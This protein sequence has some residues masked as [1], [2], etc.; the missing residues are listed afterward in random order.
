MPFSLLIPLYLDLKAS[1]LRIQ[2]RDYP[3]PAF[4]FPELHPSQLRTTTSVSI[5]GN[6]IVAEAYSPSETNIRNVDLPLVP[7][8][9]M[10]NDHLIA[11]IKRT[12]A[13]MKMFTDMAFT[14]RS[15]FPTRITYCQA[16]QPC[17]QAAMQVLTHSLNLQL[18]LP[19]SL[20]FGIKFGL[21][22]MH[23]L[24]FIGKKVISIYC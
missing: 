19:K 23:V 11:H 17:Y 18:I 14:S 8:A 9:S 16:Y 4:H 15:H 5:S 7:G 3:L 24:T 10:N 2:T 6:F 13:S 22:F 12:V 20:A 1:S 21:Y